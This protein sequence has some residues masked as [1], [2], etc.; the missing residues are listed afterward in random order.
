MRRQG[1]GCVVVDGHY[2]LWQLAQTRCLVVALMV[3][4]MQCCCHDKPC[5]HTLHLLCWLHPKLRKEPALQGM[6]ADMDVW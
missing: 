5:R 6:D 3:H 1:L 2:T 4:A